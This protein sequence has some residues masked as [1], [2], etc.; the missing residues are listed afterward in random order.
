MNGFIVN[1]VKST[2]NA[3]IKGLGYKFHVKDIVIIRV[4]VILP[5][6]F[7]LIRYEIIFEEIEDLKMV[8]IVVE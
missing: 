6:L 3:R 7:L 4:I 5:L 2:S 8:R 1:I